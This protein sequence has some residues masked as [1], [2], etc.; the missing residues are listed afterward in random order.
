M[1]NDILL[2]DEN[3]DTTSSFDTTS[4]NDNLDDLFDNLTSNIESVNKFISS[5]TNQKKVN[6]EEE[7]ELLE[8]K[9]KIN[10]TK[11]EFEG[12]MAIQKEEL[13]QKQRQMEQ[14][15]ESQ[16]AYLTKAEEE[17][18][19]N[20]DNSLTEL[21]LAKKELELQIQKNEEDK[22]QFETY[23]KL[24]MNRIHHA[25]EILSSE[26]A[27]FEKYKEVTNRKLELENKNLEQ[28][29]IRFKE[30]IGQFNL[31]FKPI[32]ESKDE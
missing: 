31:N 6:H 3:L 24:E 2:N 30:I 13:K 20:M 12:Y 4:N 25:E 27:Q 19:V 14:Y 29:C 32:L 5:L 11:E 10:R 8:E 18:K 1:N 21:D 23:K 17:F 22:E 26:K 15:L 28:K 16:K 9:E 7:L